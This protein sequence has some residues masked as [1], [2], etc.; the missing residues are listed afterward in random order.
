MLLV[1]LWLYVKAGRGLSFILGEF[2][3]DV[4]HEVNGYP[5]DVSHFVITRLSLDLA[6]P[7]A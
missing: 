7:S 1:S 4:D 2:L 5:P 6:S 3:F